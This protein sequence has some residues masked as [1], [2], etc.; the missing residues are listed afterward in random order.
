MGNGSHRADP[1]PHGSYRRRWLRTAACTLPSLA[2]VVGACGGGA[3]VTSADPPTTAAPST[4]D[5]EADG[6]L[7]CSQDRHA[8]IVDLDGT[9]TSDTGQYGRWMADPDYDPE[10]RPGAPELMRAWRERGYEIVYLAGRLSS[11][12]IGGTPIEDATLAW[13]EAHDVPAD[14]GT[15]LRFWDNESMA[16]DHYKTQTLLDLRTEGVSVEYGYTDAELD[17]TAYRAGGLAPERIFTRDPVAGD[18]GT[19]A[20]VEPTWLGHLADTVDP[21]PPVCER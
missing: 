7:P 4:T 21:L 12:T 13:L 5:D 15:H 19:T 11:S 6:L 1:R 20:V 10:L 3:E 14:E 16:I 9:V 8:V 17:I 2:L 18:Q